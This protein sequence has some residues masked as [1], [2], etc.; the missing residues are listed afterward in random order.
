MG[1]RKSLSHSP[2]GAK[3]KVEHDHDGQDIDLENSNA[4][5]KTIHLNCMH[6]KAD[7]CAFDI[8]H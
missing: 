8:A 3:K 7:K 6:K 5:G 4:S 2:G 1:Y